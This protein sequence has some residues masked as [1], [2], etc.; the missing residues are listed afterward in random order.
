[1]GSNPSQLI[2]FAL[3]SLIG[4]VLLKQPS[5]LMQRR[6]VID[7]LEQPVCYMFAEGHLECCPSL[8]VVRVHVCE[9]PDPFSMRICSGCMCGLH[10]GSSRRG[11][12][13]CGL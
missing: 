1:M 10:M 8:D 12:T 4:T 5:S 11:T 2:L 3:G 7:L 6:L 13:N 9:Y